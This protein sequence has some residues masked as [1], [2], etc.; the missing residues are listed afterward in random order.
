M[1]PVVPPREDVRVGDL[2]LFPK[3]PSRRNLLGGSSDKQERLQAM[4]R[5]AA[6]PVLT[7]LN[8]EYRSRR[9]WPRTP[10][11]FFQVA[12]DPDQRTWAEPVT[13]TPPSIFT[14]K[15]PLRLRLVGGEAMP[16]FTVT[17]G[18]VNSLIPTEAINLSMGTAWLDDKAVTIRFGGAESYSLSVQRLL[19]LLTDV[20]PTGDGPTRAVLKREFRDS[21]SLVAPASEQGGTVWIM[22]VTEVLYVR[23]MDYTIQAVRGSTADEQILASELPGVEN[24]E[25]AEGSET[26]D[27]AYGAFLRAEAINRVLMEADADDVPGGVVRFLA[28]TDDSVAVRRLWQRGLAIGVRVLRLE[29]DPVTGNVVSVSGVGP[30]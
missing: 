12:S 24:A 16:A 5:W 26:I 2:Y 8:E 22:A 17:G 4:P 7:D 20:V 18:A 13:E 23:T 10:D 9:S 6:V 28:V 30:S 27:S 14:P 21:V 19:D 15:D 1:V 11:E 3:D 29:V 25:L